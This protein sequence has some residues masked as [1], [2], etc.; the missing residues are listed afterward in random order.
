[1]IRPQHFN[2]LAKSITSLIILICL[3]I[4]TFTI[5]SKYTKTEIETVAF[6]SENKTKSI[7]PNAIIDTIIDINTATYDELCLIGLSKR[8]AKNIVSYR[9]SGGN[10]KNK[11]DLEK[12]YGMNSE[13]LKKI[14][15]HFFVTTQKEDKKKT[16][17]TVNIET[18]KYKFDLNSCDTSDLKRIP[19]IKSFRANAIIKERE[20]LGG[21]LNFDQ[22]LQIY[23]IDTIAIFSLKKHA[24]ID[25][26][27]IKKLNINSVTFKE[28]QSHP[29]CG[30]YICKDIFEYLKIQ[31]SIVSLKELV[32]NSIISQKD[33]NRL[34]YYLK[35]F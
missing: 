15:P 33:F 7:D 11:K 32:D 24:I 23:S 31:D 5:F 1:M 26:S 29:Y 12:I 25:T 22:L 18:E 3:A 20:L 28:L 19:G 8:Q 13:I 16:Y 27:N 17:N 21:F 10:F 2:R 4:L 9:N 35:T 14:Y 34:Q 30:Y 6:E